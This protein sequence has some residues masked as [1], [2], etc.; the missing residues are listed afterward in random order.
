MKRIAV[1][2]YTTNAAE[3][4]RAVEIASAIAR[5]HHDDVVIRFFTYRGNLPGGKKRTVDYE[6]LIQGFDVNYFGGDDIVLDDAMWRAFRQAELNRDGIFP[7]PY[8]VCATKYLRAVI[9]TLTEYQPDIL[10]YGLFPEVSLA[11]AIQGWKSVSFSAIERNS[12]MNWL[13]R[14]SDTLTKIGVQPSNGSKLKN[15]WRVIQNAAVECGLKLKD[16]HDFMHAICPS[17][18]ALCDFECFYDKEKLAPGVT[19]VGP[20]ISSI[21][22]SSSATM[23]QIEAFLQSADIDSQDTSC[24]KVKVL[25]SMGS[26]GKAQIFVEC[27]KALNNATP[28]DFRSVVLV[29]ACLHDSHLVNEILSTAKNYSDILI[30]KDFVPVRPILKQVDVLIC[31]G[32]Q[33]SVQ[34]GLAAG[35]PIVGVPTQADQCFNLQNVEVCNAGICILPVDW[36]EKRIREALRC[37]GNEPSYKREALKLQHEFFQDGGGAEQVAS[38]VWYTMVS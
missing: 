23:H 15:P 20:I 11:A 5:L 24:M 28:G 3:V 25:F 21:T 37:V 16:P 1:C 33:L 29:P 8:D 12:Y 32:G 31:H 14:N 36:K 35:L 30:V 6:H 38:L 10:V 19:I 22:N 27:L 9:D 26:S 7:P 13:S 18:T 34:C 2:V 17:R 4:I